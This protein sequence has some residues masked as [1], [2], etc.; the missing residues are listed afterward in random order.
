MNQIGLAA[1]EQLIEEGKSALRREQSWTQWIKRS[2]SRDVRSDTLL[3]GLGTR[4][5]VDDW[6]WKIAV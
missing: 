4:L 6:G 2:N 3:A 5:V 1:V